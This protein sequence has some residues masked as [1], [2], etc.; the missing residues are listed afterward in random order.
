MALFCIVSVC[1]RAEPP[2][3]GQCSFPSLPSSWAPTCS[4]TE[5]VGFA[6]P[7]PMAA[8]LQ[9][10][11]RPRRGQQGKL[12]QG[13]C[14]TPMPV[15]GEKIL[16]VHHALTTSSLPC[17]HGFLLFL[18]KQ[19]KRPLRER[20]AITPLALP[21]PCDSLSSSLG[22]PPPAGTELPK[23]PSPQPPLREK[24]QFPALGTSGRGS[25]VTFPVLCTAAPGDAQSCPHQSRQQEPQGA[26]QHCQVIKT[27]LCMC[28][29]LYIQHIN[30]YT[31]T[32]TPYIHT[33]AHL[34]FSV[35]K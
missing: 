8:L 6:Q 32:H 1:R 4:H 35:Y 7:A 18:G 5:A 27:N 24:M 33:Q 10:G 12:R 16:K 2:C 15:P 21:P 20:F 23:E 29:S 19:A 11:A 17:R 31:H 22:H 14:Q 26:G 13:W 28:I 3:S 9:R 25:K 34:E 30:I